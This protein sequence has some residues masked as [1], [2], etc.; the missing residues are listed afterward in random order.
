MDPSFSVL[1]GDT[2]SKQVC[3]RKHKNNLKAIE[4]AVPVVVGFFLLLGLFII[5]F[6]R[7]AFVISSFSSF[8]QGKKKRGHSDKCYE[9]QNYKNFVN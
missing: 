8:L 1:L 6:P 2:T 5:L 9:V 3:G 4:I 7:F